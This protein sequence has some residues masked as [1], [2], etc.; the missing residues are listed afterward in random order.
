MIKPHLA[1]WGSPF[2]WRG[3]IEFEDKRDE[4]NDALRRYDGAIGTDRIVASRAEA[5]AMTL[6]PG[7]FMNIG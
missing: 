1:Y 4:H 6:R 2:K 7:T 5:G 3:E